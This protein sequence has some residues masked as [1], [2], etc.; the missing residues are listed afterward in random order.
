[1]LVDDTIHH[2]PICSSYYL[3]PF[4]LLPPS[5]CV[6]DVSEAGTSWPCR[7]SF[8]PDQRYDRRFRRGLALWRREVSAQQAA[9]LR[10]GRRPFTVESYQQWFSERTLPV[11]YNCG[12]EDHI[13]RYCNYRQPLREKQFS[14]Y[15]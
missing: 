6:T 13:A 15:A 4:A 12:V 10:L 7:D 2:P 5:V 3:V 14:G 8:A 11:F 9:P 1:M